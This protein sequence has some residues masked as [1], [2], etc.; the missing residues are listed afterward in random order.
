VRRPEPGKGISTILK[1][2]H[3]SLQGFRRLII[4]EHPR[5]L[6]GR[7]PE[8]AL[9]GSALAVGDYRTFCCLRLDG[10]DAEV[11]VSSED[12]GFSEPKPLSSLQVISYHLVGLVTRRLHVRSSPALYLSSIKALVLSFIDE[13]HYLIGATACPIIGSETRWSDD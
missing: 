3:C 1:E 6:G 11:F 8:D 5:S 13:C 2:P 4:E 10:G 7:P 9:R 12:K